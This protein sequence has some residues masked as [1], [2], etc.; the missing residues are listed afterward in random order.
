AV[1]ALVTLHLAVAIWHGYAHQRLAVALSPWQDAFVL[2][3]ILATPP[4]AVAL[5]WTR[6]IRTA[7]WALVLAMLGSFAFGAYH[8]FVLVSPD[9]V[10][11]LP[12]ASAGLHGQFIATA[13]LLAALELASAIYGVI[14]LRRLRAS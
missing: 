9:H 6:W 11:H 8:H 7:L 4:L 10:A 1:S 3:V 14:A 5:A 2:V 13:V 12:A